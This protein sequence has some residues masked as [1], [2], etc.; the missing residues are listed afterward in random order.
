V[1]ILKRAAAY[2]ID[3]F[4]VVMPVSAMFH[5]AEGRLLER[6]P[7]GVEVFRFPLAWGLPMV[8]PVLVL[9]VLT[10]LTGRTPGKFLTFLKVEDGAGDPPGIAQGIVRE[11]I[12]V[13]SLAFIFGIFWA[14][15]GLATRRQTFYDDWLGLEVDDLRP[16]G[17]TPT[18][19]SFRKHRREQ[20]KRQRR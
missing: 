16:T 20:A 4:L 18:Q 15:Q 5:L 2:L 9:G 14:V 11:L 8:L 3:F 7:S 1:Y 10:G 17:L 6:F 13:V 19:K 12:K